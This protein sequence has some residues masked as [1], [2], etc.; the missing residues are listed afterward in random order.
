MFAPWADEIVGD[1][2]AFIHIAA[3]LAYPAGGS[4]GA[5]GGGHSGLGLDMLVVVGIGERRVVAQH[6][7]LANLGNKESVGAQVDSLVHLATD[8]GIGVVGDVEEAI[9]GTHFHFALL[10]LVDIAS[11]L[12]AKMLY[13]LHGGVFGEH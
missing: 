7:S 9:G 2:V 13:H 11:T 1:L 3:S 4:G 5:G 8:I 6:H 12:E 10:K